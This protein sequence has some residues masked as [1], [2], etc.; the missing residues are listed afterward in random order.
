MVLAACGS[1]PRTAGADPS[2]GWSVIGVS[3]EGRPI[4]ATTIGRG[5][6]RVLIV[7]GIHGNEREAA[8][9]LGEIERMATDESRRVTVRLI[10]DVNPDGSH[11]GTRGNARGVDLN[12]NW[13]TACFTP[14]SAHGAAPLSEPETALLIEEIERFAPGLIVVLHSAP[15]GPFVNFDGPA[16][17][18]AEAF[19]RA[20]AGAD[21]RWHVRP[22][23]GY[24]TPGSLGTWAGVERGIPILTIELRRR[25][26]ARSAELAVVEGVAAV[27]RHDFGP[28]AT[29]TVVRD[30]PAA[31][32]DHPAGAQ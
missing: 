28:P 21:P 23:I 3:I 20:A 2:A 14:R 5:P 30:G 26:D 7:G 8:G 6:R 18:A 19:A 31:A 13:P 11:A 27:L 22:S 25:Q 1:S 29:A 17:P 15:S 12:R 32:L 9:A 4:E 24:P 16:A 10:R